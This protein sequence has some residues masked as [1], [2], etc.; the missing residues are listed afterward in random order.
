MRGNAQ[1]PQATPMIS[2]HHEMN[3]QPDMQLARKR[4]F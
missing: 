3:P 2:R 4:S 1:G